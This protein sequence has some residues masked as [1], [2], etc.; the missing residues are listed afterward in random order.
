VN[1]GCAV[2]SAAPAVDQFQEEFEMRR[3]RILIAVPAAV[4]GAAA[5]V[6]A[7]PAAPPTTELYASMSGSQE[8][9]PK[10]NPAAS[11]KAE[12]KFSSKGVCYSF[13]LKKLSG[14]LTA[15]HIHTGKKGKAGPVYVVLFTKS[16]T[17]KKGKISG[18][19]SATKAQRTAI[20]AKPANYYVNVHTKKYPNGEV[21]GQLS[22]KSY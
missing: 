3:S 18:C 8:V 12:I 6:T 14:T 1:G 13:T 7:S 20:T 5:L 17:P 22:T 11:G 21:R 2:R 10:G 9:A 4:V 15:A 19:A 16:P